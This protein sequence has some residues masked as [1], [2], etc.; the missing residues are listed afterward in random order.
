MNVT[1]TDL[2]ND[3]L[4]NQSQITRTLVRN[5]SSVQVSSVKGWK[6]GDGSPG[7]QSI[8]SFQ[9]NDTHENEDSSCNDINNGHDIGVDSGIGEGEE[10]E[11]DD[12]VINLE[13]LM[14]NNQLKQMIEGSKPK[15]PT[16]NDKTE[17]LKS[18]LKSEVSDNKIMM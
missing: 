6:G 4:R 16:F 2:D 14:Q 5:P 9:G 15:E 18:V 3:E 12:E 11:E 7:K 10:M 17:N 8:A 1:E 13:I